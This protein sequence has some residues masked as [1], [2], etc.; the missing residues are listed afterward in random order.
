MKIQ[1]FVKKTIIENYKNNQWEKCWND[2]QNYIRKEQDKIKKRWE[3]Y[4]WSYSD[5]CNKLDDIQYL[6]ESEYESYFSFYNQYWICV[7]YDWVNW[8]K[9]LKNLLLNLNQN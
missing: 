1:E 9:K 7:W 8:N 3:R 2:I 5:I 6:I 4:H